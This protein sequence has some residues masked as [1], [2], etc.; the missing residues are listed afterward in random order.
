M[1]VRRGPGDNDDDVIIKRDCCMSV[2]FFSLVA[3]KCRRMVERT[4]KG[5]L[6]LV[7]SVHLG[8]TLS[9]IRIKKATTSFFC[10]PSGT[11]YQV[12]P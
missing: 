12:R 11:F 8:L 2:S 10:L 3:K 7:Q 5:L 9:K 1:I 6:F 4:R